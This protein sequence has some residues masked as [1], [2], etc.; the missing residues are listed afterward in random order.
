MQP[1]DVC[2]LKLKVR[3]PLVWRRNRDR[4][5]SSH[6]RPEIVREVLWRVGCVDEGLKYFCVGVVAVDLED[7][8]S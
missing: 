1:C 4:T 8:Q 3:E 5:N 6:Q 7:V 2:F